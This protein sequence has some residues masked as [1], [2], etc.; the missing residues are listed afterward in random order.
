MLIIWGGVA[1]MI[2][3]A[4][5]LDDNDLEPRPMPLSANQ[6]LR[7]CMRYISLA[8]NN[9]NSTVYDIDFEDIE[10]YCRRESAHLCDEAI[11]YCH[12]KMR[13]LLLREWRSYCIAIDIV[14]KK[15]NQQFTGDSLK[16][17]L[18]DL[19]IKKSDR[20]WLLNKIITLTL[21]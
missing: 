8:L 14:T 10:L 15:Y 17:L 9:N 3:L 4:S 7:Q 2:N 19:Q 5:V 1:Y 16:E 6:V 13:K 18:V 12:S 21:K 11:H 20:K